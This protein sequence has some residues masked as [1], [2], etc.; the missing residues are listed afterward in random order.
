MGIR[1]SSGKLIANVCVI[2]KVWSFLM[3]SVDVSV[4]DGLVAVKEVVMQAS[5]KALEQASQC[6]CDPRA[7][8]IVM[9]ITLAT[10]FAEK[11]D[12]YREAL[13]WCSA[14]R[15]FAPDGQAHN[16]WLKLAKELL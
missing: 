16:G 14:A 15:D 8:G 1:S 4:L 5:E 3:V 6:W 2:L 13:L 7:Q 9:D 11:I 10:I 12:Q